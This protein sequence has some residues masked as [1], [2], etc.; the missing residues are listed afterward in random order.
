MR[1]ASLWLACCLLASASCLALGTAESVEV[2]VGEAGEYSI[3]AGQINFVFFFN[4]T[5][6]D[7]VAIEPVV[8]M[9]LACL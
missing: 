9:F 1:A 3:Q 7:Q 4:R 8:A 6:E 5:E 2:E